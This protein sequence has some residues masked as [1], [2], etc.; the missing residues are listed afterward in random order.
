MALEG[1]EPLLWLG[2]SKYFVKSLV[3]VYEGMPEKRKK[4]DYKDIITKICIAKQMSK[5]RGDF[6][7]YSLF[8]NSMF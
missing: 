1:L 6:N 3:A 2:P 4:F 7:D 5:N 8:T